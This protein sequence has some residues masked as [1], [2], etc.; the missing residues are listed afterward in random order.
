MLFLWARCP[1]SVGSDKGLSLS[2]AA[3]YVCGHMYTTRQVYMPTRKCIYGSVYMSTRQCMY[4]TASESGVA[5][6]GSRVDRGVRG[7]TSLSA[8]APVCPFPAL[9]Y[10]VLPYHT[11][12]YHTIPYHAITFYGLWFTIPYHAIAFYHT[13]P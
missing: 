3:V 5:V 8:D 13:M 6:S 11:I 12:P 1:C 9:L 2:H 7:A 10:P 4:V